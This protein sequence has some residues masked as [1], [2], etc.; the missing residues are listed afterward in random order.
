MDR[1]D[2][3]P[4]QN[5]RSVG[6]TVFGIGEAAHV[7]D[8][9]DLTTEVER[10]FETQGF[11]LVLRGQAAVRRGPTVSAR[12]RIKRTDRQ[13]RRGITRFGRAPNDE[14]GPSGP[15]DDEESIRPVLDHFEHARMARRRGGGR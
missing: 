12:A 4:P 10:W 13:L 7:P 1:S 6:D 2:V 9:I 15:A 5:F 11:R 14:S 3:G 8:A